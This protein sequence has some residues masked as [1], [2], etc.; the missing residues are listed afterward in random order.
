M[1]G[2]GQCSGLGSKLAMSGKQLMESV[3]NAM[4][5]GSHTDRVSMCLT[6]SLSSLSFSEQNKFLKQTVLVSMCIDKC[7]CPCLRHL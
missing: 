4:Y 1:A 6:N 3:Y 2:P 7:W 5:S